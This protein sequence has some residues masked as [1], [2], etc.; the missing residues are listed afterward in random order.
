[1]AFTFTPC[2]ISGLYEIQPKL[3]GDSRGYF[4][5]TYSEKDFFAAGLTMRFV[6][7]NQSSSSKGV[8]RG[9]HFQKR[10]PQGKLVRAL[11]GEVYDVAVDLRVGSPTFGQYHGVVLSAEKQNQFYIPAGFAHG[12]FVL[13]DTAVFAYKCTDFYH[14]EDEGGIP[15][16]DPAFGIDWR[17]LAPGTEP[18][19]SAKDTAH[20]AFD[21][22]AAYFDENG[23]WIS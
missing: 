11:S 20:P 23:V 2:S 22:A 1:M 8:L 18:I 4:L 14:P 13:S 10:F 17:A 19:L 9:L 3:F 7:D 12:F 5:E 16:N 15:W 21:P 6:Q